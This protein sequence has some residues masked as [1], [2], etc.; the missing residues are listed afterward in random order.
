ML[1]RSLR[2]VRLVPCP[3]CWTKDLFS[4]TPLV[5]IFLWP[6]TKKNSPGPLIPWAKA[7]PHF[8]YFILHGGIILSILE[9]NLGNE[10]GKCAKISYQL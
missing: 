6:T 10:Q 8:R 1:E 9:Q 7:V 3:V 4:I 2:L 5:A